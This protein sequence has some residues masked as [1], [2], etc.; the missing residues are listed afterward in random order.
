MQ[1]C[2]TKEHVGIQWYFHLL[3]KGEISGWNEPA[4]NGWKAA[5][6]CP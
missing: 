1:S 6:K 4:C 3:S 5:P 2:Q